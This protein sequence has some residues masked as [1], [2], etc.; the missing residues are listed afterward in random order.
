MFQLSDNTGL[1][2]NFRSHNFSIFLIFFPAGL[3]NGYAIRRTR[4]ASSSSDEA[5]DN[6]ME[7]FLAVV[8]FIVPALCSR[9]GPGNTDILLV[10]FHFKK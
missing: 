6:D 3:T 8:N 9:N 2:C 5:T 4:D 7:E 10:I 1:L